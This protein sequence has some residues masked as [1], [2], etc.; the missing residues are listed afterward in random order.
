MARMRMSAR[1]GALAAIAVVAIVL[2]VAGV[3]RGF[4]VGAIELVC[5]AA[6]CGVGYWTWRNA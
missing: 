5:A 1:H 2:V 6:V 4:P 3:T